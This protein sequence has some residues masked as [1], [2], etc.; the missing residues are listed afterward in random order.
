MINRG[1]IVDDYLLEEKGIWTAICFLV[2]S[3]DSNCSH[4]CRSD[5]IFN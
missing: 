4:V 1:G 5:L 3:T 2:C